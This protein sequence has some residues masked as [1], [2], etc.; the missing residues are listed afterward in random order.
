MGT[1]SCNYSSSTTGYNGCLSN[2]PT[3]TILSIGVIVG[4]VLGSLAGIFVIICV[5][6]VT[7]LMVKKFNSSSAVYPSV[8]LHS[9]NGY[10]QPTSQN[11]QKRMHEMKSSSEPPSYFRAMTNNDPYEKL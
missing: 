9:I 11:H 5:I 4:I 8:P 6:V 10:Y 3:D 7:R 2:Y 1:T